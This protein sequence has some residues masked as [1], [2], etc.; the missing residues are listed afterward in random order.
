MAQFLGQN[1]QT[2]LSF[3]QQNYKL[4][5]HDNGCLAD[6]KANLIENEKLIFKM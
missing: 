5:Q 1:V 6:T 4:I 3:S 2:F